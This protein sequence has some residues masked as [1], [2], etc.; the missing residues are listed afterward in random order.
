MALGVN[1]IAVKADVSDEAVV[2]R[3]FET[4]DAEFGLLSVLV[5]NAAILKPQA[6]LTEMTA[7]RVNAMLTANVTSAMRCESG[8]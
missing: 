7:E 5:N 2:M 3:L 6:R 4:V 1:C 8:R